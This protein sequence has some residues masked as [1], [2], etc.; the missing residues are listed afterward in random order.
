MK[1]ILIL[2]SVLVGFC[3]T[4]QERYELA[5]GSTLK[6]HGTSTAHDWT[7]VAQKMQGSLQW[8]AGTIANLTFEVLV[9]D[10]QS[11][12]GAAMNKKMHTAL[13]MDAHPKVR[14]LCEKAKNTDSVLLGTLGIAGV[15]RKVELNV[16][17]LLSKESIRFTGEKEL[18]LQDFDMKP[19][20]AMFG[21]IVVG[22]TVRVQF[23]LVFTRN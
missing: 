10:I 4:A 22:D 16:D 12:R 13:K 7:V 11:E 23:D 15:D 6:I 5:A 2:L 9:A 21:Q 18:V 17:P 19:P 20:S 14:F 1:K 3:G 8:E